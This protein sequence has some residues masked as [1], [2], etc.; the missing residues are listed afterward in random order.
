M[1]GSIFLPNA[2][3]AHKILSG[4]ND[5]LSFRGISQQRRIHFECSPFSN[6]AV[7]T[8]VS[9]VVFNDAMHYEKSIHLYRM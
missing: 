7:N 8:D 9:A 5:S 2:F 6:L 1:H 4:V 3:A